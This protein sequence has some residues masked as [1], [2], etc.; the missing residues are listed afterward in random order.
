MSVW[1]KLVKQWHFLGRFK[2][3][4][5][6]VNWHSSLLIVITISASCA[7]SA[8]CWELKISIRAT[9]SF[10][11]PLISLFLSINQLF[12]IVSHCHRLW[13]LCELWSVWL[14]GHVIFLLRSC[15]PYAVAWCAP[16]KK[17]NYTFHPSRLQ[18]LRLVSLVAPHFL[19]RISCLSFSFRLKGR[20]NHLLW[21]LLSFP[22]FSYFT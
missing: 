18:E 5:P 6:A 3:L 17:C 20:T 11:F 4:Y 22:R 8:L 15:V 19:L 13:F 9:V 14:K 16:P 21:R 7:S 2:K 12:P 1:H 10:I